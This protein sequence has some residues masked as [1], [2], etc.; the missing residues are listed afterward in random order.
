MSQR[1]RGGGLQ[2]R[3]C[4]LLLQRIHIPDEETENPCACK[5]CVSLARTA[6]PLGFGAAAAGAC[7]FGFSTFGGGCG[8]E[9]TKVTR[10]VRPSNAF[11]ES[12]AFES[13]EGE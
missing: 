13:A 2:P 7:R 5:S 11:D 1:E 8:A 12:I 4:L 10:I 9:A 3:G 6:G